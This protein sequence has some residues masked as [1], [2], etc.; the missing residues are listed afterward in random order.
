M[1]SFHGVPRRSLD[2]GDPYHCHCHKTARL[3]A[4]ELGLEKSQ[5]VLTFQ[6]RFGKAEWLQPYT[7][8]TLARLP[9]EGVKRVDVFCPGFVADCL[10]TLEEIGIEGK[11]TFIEAG[12]REFHAI[13]CL[14]E[15]PPGSPRWPNSSWPSCPAGSPRRPTPR[16][17]RRRCSGPRRWARPADA[18]G[19]GR[20]TAA[21][22]RPLDRR[23]S[24]GRPGRPLPAS[25][26]KGCRTDRRLDPVA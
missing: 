13:P 3:L 26:A 19:P 4:A 25:P 5:Y 6:S 18:T 14:N 22:G 10:E 7:A 21:S 15:H 11:A 16:R 20:R 12:G 23:R 17:A 24:S 2:L 8:E 1:L 9:G